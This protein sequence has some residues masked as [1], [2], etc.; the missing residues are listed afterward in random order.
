MRWTATK[1]S[2]K[3]EAIGRLGWAMVN[4]LVWTARFLEGVQVGQRTL[5]AL[6]QHGQ[7]RQVRLLSALAF[8]ISVAATMPRRRRCSTRRGRLP[9]KSATSVQSPDVLHVQT[10][11][12][13]VYAEFPEES[14]SVCWRRDV[15]ARGA[16]WDLCSVQAFVIFEDGSLGSR[17][18]ATRLADKALALA[19]RLG[20]LG[21][22]FLVLSTGSA[23]GRDDR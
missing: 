23:R 15:R 11:H 2:D 19:E 7:R 13:F 22:A 14:G 3:S 9:S 6:R 12:H 16:L 17:D 5:A 4:Q 18:Q 20:H 1:R 10:I 8:A 21:A